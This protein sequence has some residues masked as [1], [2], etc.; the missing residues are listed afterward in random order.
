MK[1][2]RSF[3]KRSIIILYQII[4]PRLDSQTAIKY[5]RPLESLKTNY[6]TTTKK[7]REPNGPNMEEAGGQAANARMR[8]DE[9][10]FR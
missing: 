10:A 3:I 8:N 6:P 7:T 5:S 9:D 4:S 1:G 2:Q